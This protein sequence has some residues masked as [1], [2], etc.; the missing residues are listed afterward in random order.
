MPSS[1][2][3]NSEVA[4]S[5][6]MNHDL[7]DVDSCIAVRSEDLI[8]SGPI[9]RGEAAPSTEEDNSWALDPMLAIERAEFYRAMAFEAD[10]GAK[11]AL[12]RLEAVMHLVNAAERDL[13][14]SLENG[15]AFEGTTMQRA[16][17]R[18][19]QNARAALAK[20]KE[21]L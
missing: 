11:Q 14:R 2:G 7:D 3:A 17:V 10:R 12:A 20:A 21:A 18:H 8:R 15:W 5:D 4:M 6:Q 1:D 16:I 13:G 19:V 9:E